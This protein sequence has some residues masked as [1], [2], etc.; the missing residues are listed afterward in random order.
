MIP[1]DK[2]KKIAPRFFDQLPTDTRVRLLPRQAA[3]WR[4]AGLPEDGMVE[5]PLTLGS[6]APSRGKKS[7]VRLSNRRTALPR[8]A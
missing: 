1:I 7:H 2:L 3:M 8:N 4:E 5:I 6:A